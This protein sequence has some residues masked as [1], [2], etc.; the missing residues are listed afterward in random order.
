[1]NKELKRIIIVLVVVVIAVL[2][3]G[4]LIYKGSSK[5]EKS[6]EEIKDILIKER[7]AVSGS[8]VMAMYV[9]ANYYKNKGYDLTW[10]EEL[11]TI[12]IKGK[13]VEGYEASIDGIEML[14]TT[15][16]VLDKEGNLYR[17]SGNQYETIKIGDKIKRIG[18]YYSFVGTECEPVIHYALDTDAGYKY[19]V[20]DYETDNI[21]IKALNMKREQ[22][23]PACYPSLFD[24]KD[25]SKVGYLYYDENLNVTL[26][27]KVLKDAN[28]KKNIEVAHIVYIDAK[29]KERYYLVT[30][31]KTLYIVDEVKEFIEPIGKLDSFEVTKNDSPDE[32]NI[33]IKM[34]YK[35]V[36]IE[37]KEATKVQG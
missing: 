32:E 25:F 1:M 15:T 14:V 35:D 16:Y 37:F 3:V 19:I 13:L 36:V 21:S 24:H 9:D 31:D 7:D 27:S 18:V 11:K 30:E 26:N 33:D 34:S 12:N 10:F 23:L 29:D 6:P 5:K 17:H 4:F 2:F 20:E 22:V 28:S 8:G